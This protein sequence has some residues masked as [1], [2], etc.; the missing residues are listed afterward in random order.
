[1]MTIADIFDALTA[2]DRPYKKAVPVERALGI[3][4]SEVK[5]G[6]CDAELF[7]IFVEGEVYGR[8]CSERAGRRRTSV[9][10]RS[11]AAARRDM[12]GRCTVP[13]GGAA[14]ALALRGALAA[15][16]GSSATLVF[17][18]DEEIRV[19]NRDLPASTTAPP[20][21]SL[22][23]AGANGRGQSGRQRH[24]PRRHRHLGRDGPAPRPPRTLPRRAR[25]TGR[26]RALPPVR[27]RSQAQARGARDVRARAPPPPAAAEPTRSGRVR[28]RALAA[29]P[30]RNQGSI[31]T[32]GTRTATW[33]RPLR[34]FAKTRE[35]IAARCREKQFP[36]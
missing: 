1:M 26:P 31:V 34:P 22:P 30:W 13:G 21:C 36:R 28:R 32:G 25:E 27:P 16:L 14:C 4:E 9:R 15:A 8:S 2:T 24:S 29:S 7:R 23:P 20:T 10:G 12:R 19:L 3:L 6:K 35:E 5:A 33:R 11:R 17:T 18:D